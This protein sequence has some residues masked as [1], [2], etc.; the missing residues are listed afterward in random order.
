MND[1]QRCLFASLNFWKKVI[2]IAR[3]E[4]GEGKTG[5]V[6]GLLVDNDDY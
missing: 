6:L 2:I 1:P 5:L 4:C 3:Q